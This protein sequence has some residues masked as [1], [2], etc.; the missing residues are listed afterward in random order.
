M[1]KAKKQQEKKFEDMQNKLL[2]MQQQLEVRKPY[3]SMMEKL[4]QN[5]QVQEIVK[6]ELSNTEAL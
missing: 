2:E 5:E 3:E 6:S 1:L 4:L